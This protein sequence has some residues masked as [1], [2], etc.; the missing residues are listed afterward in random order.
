MNQIKSIRFIR[1]EKLNCSC[2]EIND[3]YWENG[4]EICGKCK[5][6]I[7]RIDVEKWMREYDLYESFRVDGSTII[8]TRGPSVF[9]IILMM[10][11]IIYFFLFF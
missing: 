7:E 9:I 3:V 10:K 5:K 6:I 11:K 1:S 4:K 2:D 8:G